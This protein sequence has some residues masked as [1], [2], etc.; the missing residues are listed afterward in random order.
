MKDRSVEA[1]QLLNNRLFTESFDA[2]RE[3]LITKLRKAS[4]LDVEEV[5]ELTRQI[6]TADKFKEILSRHITTSKFAE[7]NEKA[8]R[9]REA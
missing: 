9:L 8:R 3:E 4:L 7:H 5:L 1:E 2:I 6:Q